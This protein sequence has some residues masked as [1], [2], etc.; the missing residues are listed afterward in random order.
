[1][2]SVLYVRVRSSLEREELER[3]AI[4]RR[5]RFEEVP[6]LLQKV[7]GRDPKTGDACGI[8]FFDNADSLAR[9]KESELARTIPQAYEAV[10]VRAEV[11]E[12]MFSL[13]PE[14]G[15]L[16]DAPGTS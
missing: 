9:Y 15:P 4:E 3:R 13:R 1:M 2:A 10:D 12:V 5:P 7:Y 6:G 8:Y 14:R 16:T 11:Y